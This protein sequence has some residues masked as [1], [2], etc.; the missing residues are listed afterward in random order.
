MCECV[1]CLDMMLESTLVP[2]LMVYEPRP[3][4]ISMSG[5][6]VSD[7]EDGIFHNNYLKMTTCCS[8]SQLKVLHTGI[9]K[10]QILD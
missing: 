4:L 2:L 1:C 10:K 3:L 6:N 8:E 7:H 5:L 9:T